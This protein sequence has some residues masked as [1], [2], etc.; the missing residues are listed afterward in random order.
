M[1]FIYKVTNKINGKVYIGK[2]VHSVERRMLEHKNESKTNT[3]GRPFHCAIQ[4]Y[5]FDNFSVETLEE[6]DNSILDSR[7]M[8]WISFY[9]SYVGFTGSNGY[10]ATKGGDGTLKVD[11]W[12]I[13][14]DYLKTGCKENTAK[15]FGVCVETVRNACKSFGIDTFINTSGRGIRRISDDGKSKEYSSIK[16]AAEE[17]SQIIKKNPVTIRKRITFVVNHKSNQK[18]YGYSWEAV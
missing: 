4:K 15:Y 17:L 8:F 12:Q 13:V 7:E 5:G 18:A 1:G 14:S 2:T 6:V 10:N 16:S 9:R 11:Y 3:F